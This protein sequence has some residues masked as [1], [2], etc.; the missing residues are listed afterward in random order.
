MNP[1]P[2]AP[3]EVAPLLLLVTAPS[4]AGKTTVGQGLLESV[5]GLVRAVTCTTRA[6]RAGERAGIDYH[7]LTPAEFA[8]R[9][10]AGEF[11]EHA[12]VYGNRYGTLRSEVFRR[13]EEGADVLLTVDV[14]GAATIRARAATD[15]QLARALVSVFIMPPSV[16]ELVRR[17]T[18]R[19]QDAAEVI[20]RRLREAREEMGQWRQCDYVVVSG[21]REEDL[22]AMQRIVAAERLRVAR[23]VRLA[24]G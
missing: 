9:V 7:Y 6:P 16:D 10:A 14:Q 13:L 15:E 12:E 8:A 21:S 22:A 23:T 3:R 17:L 18:G 4:G 5:P 11:L 19:N 2:P 24:V 1:M 20:A